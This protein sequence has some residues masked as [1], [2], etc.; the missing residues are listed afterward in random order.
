MWPEDERIAQYQGSKEAG[1][2]YVGWKEDSSCKGPKMGGSLEVSV[3]GKGE[4]RLVGDEDEH[5]ATLA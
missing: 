3:A 2:G 1:D 4:Q 5:I